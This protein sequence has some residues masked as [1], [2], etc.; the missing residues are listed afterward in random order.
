M[1]CQRIK[2]RGHGTRNR[3]IGRP[4]EIVVVASQTIEVDAQRSTKMWLVLRVED[5]VN[6]LP[7][8]LNLARKP[9]CGML[10]GLDF[11]VRHC[12]D[13]SRSSFEGRSSGLPASAP[14]NVPLIDH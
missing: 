6:Q 5:V 12:P 7:E 9:K 14:L 11:F 2:P 4:D 10:P 8:M 1:R 3:L 13:A